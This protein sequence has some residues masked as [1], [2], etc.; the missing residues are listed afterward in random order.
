MPS[1][2]LVLKGKT[3]FSSILLLPLLTPRVY[4]FPTPTSSL[5]PAECP[6]GTLSSFLFL[7]N[8]IYL[9]IFGSA[10]S[11]L[12]RGHVLQLQRVGAFLRCSARASHCGGFSCAEY[13]L[14]GAW[15]SVVVPNGLNSCASQAL[16]HRLSYSQVY[17]IFLDRGS[18]SC[19][20]H[21]QVD[22]LPLSQQGSP[23]FSY[24]TLRTWSQ[25][26]IPQ[27]RRSVPGTALTSETTP[28][29]LDINQWFPWSPPRVQ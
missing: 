4:G 28:E 10:G 3:L 2:E 19:L 22:S 16:E 27:V 15:A 6:N 20:R 17:G 18:N 12:L 1:I 14:H 25:G 11:L 13:G 21:G 7:N 24:I 26:P 29:L 23:L 8:C 9:F 5:T